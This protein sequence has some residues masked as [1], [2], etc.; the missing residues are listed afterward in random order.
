MTGFGREVAESGRERIAAEVRSVNGRGLKLS[1]RLP[2]AL[3]AF[4]AEV[5][6]LARGRID[7]GSVHVELDYRAVASPES[8]GVN[9]ELLSALAEEVRAAKRAL[10]NEAPVEVERLLSLPGVV[11]PKAPPAEDAAALWGRVRAVVER[12]L[13]ALSASRLREGAALAEDLRARRR[14][15]GERL[16]AVRARLPEVVA[17]QKRK[18][19]ERLQALLAS[20]GVAPEPSTLVREA[21]LLA[22]RADVSEEISRL[23]AHLAEMDRVLEA[24]GPVG[25]RLEFLAQEMLREA[26]TMGSK[27]QESA[28]IHDILAIKLEIDKVKEQTANVE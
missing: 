5:E 6:A 24:S 21:A 22:E 2:D 20:S 23:D 8:Y 9:R 27:S 10:G 13:E 4:Q 14:A 11:V 25:R 18:L 7:R 26:N 1:V 16:L 15:I 28:L 3:L 19:E 17:A 12:A